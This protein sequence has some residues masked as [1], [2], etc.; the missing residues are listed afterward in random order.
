[1]GSSNMQTGVESSDMWKKS[2]GTKI[3]NGLSVIEVESKASNMIGQQALGGSVLPQNRKG[4]Q[5]TGWTGSTF[6]MY[7]DWSHVPLY[8]L[9]CPLFACLKVFGLFHVTVLICPFSN[10]RIKKGKCSFLHIYQLS[11]LLLHWLNFLRLIAV[12]QSDDKFDGYLFFKVSMHCFYFEC[13][14][15][16]TMLYCSIANPKSL[17]E[18][19]RLW[20]AFSGGCS[21]A[22][23]MK[24]YGFRFRKIVRISVFISVCLVVINT[25]SIGFFLL[26]PD[27]QKEAGVILFPFAPDGDHA[28]TAK[29]AFILIHLFVNAAFVLP[30][31]AFFLFACALLFEFSAFTRDFSGNVTERGRFGGDFEKFRSRH[32]R[33]CD[34]LAVTDRTFQ[35]MILAVY[36]ITIAKACFIGYTIIEGL[37]SGL[38]LAASIYWMFLAALVIGMMTTIG[39]MVNNAVS[40]LNTC[41]CV[42]ICI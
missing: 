28:L 18:F 14:F 13:A 24:C 40:S 33:I 6:K 11:M 4:A 22:E 29:I 10:V 9:M 32:Q 19:F 16:P 35:H 23:R 20:K 12:Y 26:I 7:T 36:A 25:V 17:P 15:Y 8:C 27:A 2:S 30:L 38:G 42:F 31:T 37:S 5:E 41:V 39:A 34:L 3:N 21:D 1:M